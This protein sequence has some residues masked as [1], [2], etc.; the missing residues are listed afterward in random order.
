M[1]SHR[2]RKTL[3]NPLRRQLT[4]FRVYSHVFRVPRDV[5]TSYRDGATVWHWTVITE[6]QRLHGAAL[7][8]NDWNRTGI[9]NSGQNSAGIWILDGHQFILSYVRMTSPVS[10]YWPKNSSKIFRIDDSLIKNHCLR[11][12]PNATHSYQ[13]PREFHSCCIICPMFKWRQLQLHHT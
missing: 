10:D 12:Y 9:R 11:R 13:Y 8:K 7:V 5:M 1:M 2:T 4:F 3:R 6:Q